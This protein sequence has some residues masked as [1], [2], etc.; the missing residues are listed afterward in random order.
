MTFLGATVTD[1]IPITSMTGNVSFAA[2]SYA[3]AGRHDGRRP[4]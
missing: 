2:L 1:I 3:N 4:P